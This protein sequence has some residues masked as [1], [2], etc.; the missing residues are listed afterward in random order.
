MNTPVRLF[1]EDGTEY[2]RTDAVMDFLERTLKYAK[3]FKC[4]AAY[5]RA[6]EYIARELKLL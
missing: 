5:I 4:D 2:I 3:E 1:H 6:I